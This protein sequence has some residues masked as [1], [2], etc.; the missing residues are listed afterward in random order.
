MLAL[1]ALDLL[2]NLL[3]YML[4][5]HTA[6][7]SVLQ[8]AALLMPKIYSSMTAK[9]LLPAIHVGILRLH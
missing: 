4:Y 9:I 3:I 6:R 1:S 2:A 5:L 7:L 8:F